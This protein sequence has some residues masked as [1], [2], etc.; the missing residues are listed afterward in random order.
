[1]LYYITSQ[2]IPNFHTLIFHTTG[3]DSLKS[4]PGITLSM[5]Y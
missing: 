3:P 2:L 1:M 4:K 5:I